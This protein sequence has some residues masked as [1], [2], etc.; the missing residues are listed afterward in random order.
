[1]D[2][3]NPDQSGSGTG[4]DHANHL[5]TPMPGCTAGREEPVTAITTTM[6]QA[7]AAMRNGVTP[8]RIGGDGTLIEAIIDSE[9]GRDSQ[10]LTEVLDTMTEGVEE[11]AHR[12]SRF[13]IPRQQSIEHLR[14]PPRTFESTCDEYPS[15]SADASSSAVPRRPTTPPLPPSNPTSTSP[16]TPPFLHLFDTGHIS[17][18]GEGPRSEAR[19]SPCTFRHWAKGAASYPR[20]PIQQEP[21]SPVNTTRTRPSTP[22][23]PA[24]HPS[25]DR[26]ANLSYTRQHDAYTGSEFSAHY[27]V[28]SA[29]SAVWTPT[30]ADPRRLAPT[31]HHAYDRMNPAGGRVLLEAR[32]GPLGVPSAPAA[33]EGEGESYS[34]EEVKAALAG[35]RGESLF[36]GVPGRETEG[37]I[38]GCYEEIE[39]VGGE[40]ERLGKE[41]EG[42]REELERLR[43]ERNEV[44]W[45][46][47]VMD[48]KERLEARGLSEEGRKKRE[49]IRE[50]VAAHM[51]ELKARREAVA[52]EA[53]VKRRENEWLVGEVSTL[54]GE[55]EAI[56]KS[57][58]KEGVEEVRAEHEALTEIEKKSIFL[59]AAEKE[60]MAL[61]AEAEEA[62]EAAEAE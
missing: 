33:S 11:P 17:D 50:H 19:I 21:S 45:C 24:P 62:A 10:V 55:V 9:P 6:M 58:G 3:H 56:C 42:L 31:H 57:M 8:N 47:M 16:A 60:R 26:I 4:K 20:Q 28:P 29:P 30:G 49:R 38:R 48:A 34:A 25:P 12:I 43:A 1:M 18:D 14:Y 52:E 35:G 46:R 39:R 32:Y 7:Y 15:T 36:G 44:G 59:E 53:R 22:P 54:M 41:N 27:R 51:R 37:W 13:T 40:G 5:D 2:N 61:L 23:I